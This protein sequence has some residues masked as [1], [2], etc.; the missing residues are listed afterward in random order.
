MEYRD[1]L[2]GK[3]AVGEFP[4]RWVSR[5]SRFVSETWSSLPPSPSLCR[6]FEVA[7]SR[8]KILRRLNG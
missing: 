3:G 8:G 2:E 4:N 7:S 6:H 1:K 5:V